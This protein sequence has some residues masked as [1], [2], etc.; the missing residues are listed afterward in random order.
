MKLYTLVKRVGRWLPALLML[1]SFAL[2][3]AGLAQSKLRVVH[4]MPG[5]PALDVKVASNAHASGIGFRD[6]TKNAPDLSNFALVELFE[7]GTSTKLNFKT[8]TLA[9]DKSYTLYVTGTPPKTLEEPTVVARP[10]TMSFPN[11]VSK[12]AVVHMGVDAGDLD[13]VITDSKNAKK[14]FNQM[15]YKE[16]RPH[17]DV[18]FGNFTVEVAQKGGPVFYRATG[19]IP[20]STAATIIVTGRLAVPGE[21]KLAMLI[22]SDDEEQKPLDILTATLENKQAKYRFVNLVPDAPPLDVYVDNVQPAFVKDVP[23]RSAS[24]LQVTGDGNRTLKF[25]SPTPPLD[26]IFLS[27]S[28]KLN[29]DTIYTVTGIGAKAST[30]EIFLLTHPESMQVP[31]GSAKFRI[32]HASIDAGP[33]DVKITKSNGETYE[34][35]NIEYKSLTQ[36]FDIP[37]GSIRMDV[38]PAG[39]APTFSGTGM[40]EGGTIYT[41]ALSGRNAVADEFNV[42]LIDEST[43]G[44][45]A[46]IGILTRVAVGEAMVRVVHLVPPVPFPL[47]IDIFVDAE[48]TPRATGLAYRNATAL[49]KFAPGEHTVKVRM[50]G[51]GP[52]GTGIDAPVV[53]NADTA[54]TVY[55]F[56]LDPN[57]PLLT[58][59]VGLAP[60]SSANALVRVLHA[61]GDAGNVDIT[62]VDAMGART[63]MDDIAPGAFTDYVEIP[64]GSV[65]VDV[66]AAGG[67]LFY[68]A[69]GSV[70]AEGILT[71]VAS[72]S[73]ASDFALNVVDDR[74]ENEQKPLETLTKVNTGTGVDDDATKIAGLAVAPNPAMTSFGVTV[75][76]LK[77]ESLNVTLYD[78][79]GASIAT[80]A[81]GSRGNGRRSIVVPTDGIPAGMYNVVVTGDGGSVIGVR[82]VM[83]VK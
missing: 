25:V 75:D 49:T 14:T 3:G 66:S 60:V 32:L 38:G 21:F 13:I 20:T 58:R 41:F 83:V 29:P 23:W 35:K 15:A 26:S 65:T 34:R 78:L 74:D 69:T 57:P 12:F 9:A 6:A 53:L 72:G 70:S 82:P 67:E 71:I 47:T 2:P 62:L 63:E 22:D 19:N 10:R 46:P 52:N 61:S 51:S 81:D 24:S 50:T 76:L 16:A 64:A 45:Q 17:T 48:Q 40:V 54:Y 43:E 31:G 39:E 11:G 68:R 1:A 42:N 56:S 77:D 37:E 5:G 18:D 80:V 27:L 4:A 44:E 73:K 8:Y 79:L 7:A 36:Y 59:A 55:A 28:R 30:K 33:V